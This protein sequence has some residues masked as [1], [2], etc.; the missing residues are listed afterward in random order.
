VYIYLTA[1][2]FFGNNKKKYLMPSREYRVIDCHLKY[3]KALYR[4]FK[5]LITKFIIKYGTSPKD[6]DISPKNTNTS[7]INLETLAVFL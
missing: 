4:L 1:A 7:L 6:T 5:I 2:L 3:N